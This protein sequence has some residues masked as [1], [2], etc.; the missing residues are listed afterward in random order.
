MKQIK[1]KEVLP[2]VLVQQA[3]TCKTQRYLAWRLSNKNFTCTEQEDM[4]NIKKTSW[5]NQSGEK[6]RLW[7]LSIWEK[8][9][10]L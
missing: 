8:I 3:V 6:F 10:R 7:K 9:L 2:K 4:G 5:R 1:L